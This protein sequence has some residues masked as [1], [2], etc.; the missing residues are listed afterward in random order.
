MLKDWGSVWLTA[1]LTLGL[2]LGLSGEGV[3]HCDG[4]DGPV[5]IAA[6]KALER[7]DVNLV[8]VWVQPGDEAE[9]REAFEKL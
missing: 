1:A 9:I 3:A 2:L 7:G 4:L 5:V 6:K 8:L